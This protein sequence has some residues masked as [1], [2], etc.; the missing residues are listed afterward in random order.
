M[1]IFNSIKSVI[2][3]FLPA[4]TSPEQAAQAGVLVEDL[5]SNNAIA[6][7]SKS[8]C[9]YCVRAKDLLKSLGQE[10]NTKTVE[11]DHVSN[12]S[13]IQEYLATRAQKGRVTVPQIYIHQKLVGGCS[14]L[15]ALH[16]AGKLEALLKGSA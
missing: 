6:V 2:G 3:S 13:A 12:G 11:L 10:A 5:I 9:P 15:Q 14:E 7:F 16:S 4:G 8:Y 1:G